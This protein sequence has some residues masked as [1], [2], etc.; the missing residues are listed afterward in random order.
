VDHPVQAG[1]DRSMDLS[2]YTLEYSTCKLVGLNE[3]PIEKAA[4]RERVL[5]IVLF[6]Q[7]GAH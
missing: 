6:V 5:L 1:G 3:A 2:D 7:L 4:R